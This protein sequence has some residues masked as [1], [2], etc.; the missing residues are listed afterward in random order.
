MSEHTVSRYCAASCR[1]VFVVLFTPLVG[2]EQTSSAFAWF[3]L[4]VRDATRI[5]VLTRALVLL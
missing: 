4:E 3:P 5:T 2:K 1:A